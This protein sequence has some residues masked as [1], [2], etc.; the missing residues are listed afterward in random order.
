MNEIKGVASMTGWDII[1]E[2]KAVS[3]KDWET[4]LRHDL[5]SH[6]GLSWER[7][8]RKTVNALAAFCHHCAA[9]KRQAK[10][11]IAQQTQE[12]LEQQAAGWIPYDQQSPEEQA[13]TRAD[14]AAMWPE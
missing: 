12:A 9:R 11:Y 13:K 4:A 5:C 1:D 7:Q 2:Q 8:R 14:W 6:C 3:Q 10:E